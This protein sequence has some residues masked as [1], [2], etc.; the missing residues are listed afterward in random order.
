M[1]NKIKKIRLEVE[2]QNGTKLEQV[3]EN[4]AELKSLIEGLN[5]NPNG[6]H[7]DKEKV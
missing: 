6:R 4:Y 7:S 3:P 2:Y 5:K 1:R